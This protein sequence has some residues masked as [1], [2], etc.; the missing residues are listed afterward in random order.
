MH[1]QPLYNKYQYFT[2]LIKT[3]LYSEQAMAND[4]L[5]KNL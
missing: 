3:L 2:G 1:D 5:M 4:Y